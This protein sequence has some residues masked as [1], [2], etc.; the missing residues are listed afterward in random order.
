MREACQGVGGP[1]RVRY[2][3]TSGE[4]CAFAEGLQVPTEPLLAAM[5]VSAPGEIKPQS[6][7]RRRG[8]DRRPTP[9]RQQRE[10]VEQP[11]IGVRLVGTD[12]QIRN[13]RPG[14]RRGHAHVDAT[15]HRRAARG[16][17]FLPSSDLAD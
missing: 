9:Y 13:Q 5:E 16:H 6:V 1:R 3:N 4:A 14:V 15:R 17:D 8:R 7:R 2:S 10:A 11:D 12:V